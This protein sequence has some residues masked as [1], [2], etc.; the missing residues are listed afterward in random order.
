MR[1]RRERDRALDDVLELAHVAGEG[2]GIERAQGVGREPADVLVVLA[3]EALEEVAREL[4]HV[5]A[6][7]AERRRAR[8]G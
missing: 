8:R 4:G 5:L 3:R 7:L 2:V 6:A 1:A